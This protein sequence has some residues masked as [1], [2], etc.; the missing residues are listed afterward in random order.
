M[1]PDVIMA[2]LR[3]F[4]KGFFAGGL[5]SVVLIVGAGFQFHNLADLKT[6]LTSLL[7][8]FLTGGI[9]AVEKM[10][11]YTPDVQQATTQSPQTPQA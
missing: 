4:G 5:A 9:L 11:N 1:T 6:W 7:F 8:A 3:R 2:G 10:L